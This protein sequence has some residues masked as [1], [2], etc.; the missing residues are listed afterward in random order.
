[1]RGSVLG[2]PVRV[3]S[4]RD[5]GLAIAGAAHP[6]VQGFASCT[7]GFRLLHR[8][9][10]NPLLWRIGEV[11]SEVSAWSGW[12]AGGL[13]AYR[14]GSR[15]SNLGMFWTPHCKKGWGPSSCGPYEVG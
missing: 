3:P 5:L 1:M 6:A 8:S 9:W 12:A 14:F 10:F 4:K 15:R 7:Q 2:R 11:N 13:D